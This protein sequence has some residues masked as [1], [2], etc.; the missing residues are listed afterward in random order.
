MKTSSAI[1]TR[2]RCRCS[3]CYRSEIPSH[4]QILPPL[5]TV[6]SNWLFMEDCTIIDIDD[7]RPNSVHH[8]MF[9][10][11][12]TAVLP[13]GR[14]ATKYQHGDMFCC[15]LLS[16][17]THG[18]NS[19]RVGG[20]T[21]TRSI[22]LSCSAGEL[23]G[24]KLSQGHVQTRRE[25]TRYQQGAQDYSGLVLVP[26]NS[27]NFTIRRPRTA[28]PGVAILIFDVLVRV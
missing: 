10:T 3:I 13:C 12:L 26:T 20:T 19:D 14:E 17:K 22:L 18:V 4:Q 9:E 21:R 23:K 15:L 25:R 8:L 1:P 27:N 6:A 11:K 2:L 5:E 16:K 28:H 7:R 24:F